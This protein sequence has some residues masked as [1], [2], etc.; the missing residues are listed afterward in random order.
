M[1]ELHPDDS[2]RDHVTVAR[3]KAHVRRK[4]KVRG[5]G[6][7]FVGRIVAQI[8]GALACVVLGIFILQ[9]YQEL[10]LLETRTEPAAPVRAP[11]QQAIAMLPLD[12]FSPDPNDAYFAAG[13]TEVLIS[14]LAQLKDWSVVSRTSA[15]PMR[16]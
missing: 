12:S 16:S 3:G 9:Q 4:D 11:G 13:M 5:V 10:Q 2:G 14:D 8:I 7:S 15:L 1:P 6:I